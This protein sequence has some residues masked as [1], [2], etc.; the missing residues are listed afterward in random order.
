MDSY[1]REPSRKKYVKGHGFLSF[2]RNLSEKYGK[3]TIAYC[4]ENRTA[5][6]KKCFQKSNLKNSWSNKWI[7][8]EQNW[9]KIWETKTCTQW[10]FEKYWRNCYFTREKME[11]LNKLRQ[12][13]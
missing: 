12:V 10:E 4:S 13:L 9:W 1:S 6:C 7:D 3:E 8:R 5:H 2:A 11:I